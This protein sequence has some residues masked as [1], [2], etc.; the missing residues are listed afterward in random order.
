MPRPDIEAKRGLAEKVRDKLNDLCL[1]YNVLEGDDDEVQYAIDDVR[2]HITELEGKALDHAHETSPTDVTLE[3]NLE[4]YRDA[5]GDAE[6]EAIDTL[7][8]A[9]FSKLLEGTELPEDAETAISK[10]ESQ[11][12]LKAQCVYTHSGDEAKQAYSDHCEGVKAAKAEIRHA[13]SSLQREVG[14]L[15]G[16][17]AGTVDP[18]LASSTREALRAE[19]IVQYE[20]EVHSLQEKAREA[21]KAGYE[22]C[23]RDVRACYGPHGLPGN[24]HHG[25]SQERTEDGDSP[26]TRGSDE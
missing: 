20:A 8:K 25:A 26:S 7:I 13:L 2:K 9:Q 16:I 15:K 23:E 12:S 4:R 14:E 22:R 19:L 21:E 24:R 10:L 18:L 3:M 1:S 17:V 11:A 5:E 6:H